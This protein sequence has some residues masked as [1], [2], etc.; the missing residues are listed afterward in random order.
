MAK[1]IKPMACLNHNIDSAIEAFSCLRQ[2]AGPLEH[3]AE[4]VRTCLAGG[5]KLLTAGN[6]GSF[7]DAAHLATEFVCRFQDDR[8]PFP[9]LLLGEAGTLTAVGNDYEFQDV[10]ARQV[11]AF[12][13]QG[14]VLVVISSSGRSENIRRALQVAK[15]C[16][17]ESIA[18]LG[19][20]GGF[21]AGLATVEL[22]VPGQ[23]TAR[24]QEA[25]KLLYHTLC[26]LVEPALTDS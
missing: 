2:L 7:A 11:K 23:V 3:A 17:L 4:L 22:I 19:G 9:A 25:Q 1:D 14:D 20:D 26:E 8:D 24:I 12:G 21:C 16:D 5:H 15:D 10:F 6:G 13:R 18:L